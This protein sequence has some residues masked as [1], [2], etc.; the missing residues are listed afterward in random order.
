MLVLLLTAAVASLA[1]GLA[2]VGHTEQR[3][4]A[5]H[6]RGAQ[7][8]YA[9]DAAVR[10]AMDAIS[11]DSGSLL[12]PSQGTI[13]ALPGGA[14]IMA[15]AAGETVDLDARTADLNADAVRQWP[16]G[17]D[18]PRWR[19]VAWGGLPEMGTSRRVAIWIADDVIDADGIPG[20][21]RNGMLMI[22]VEAF[23]PRGAAHAV[24][25]HVRREAGAVRTVSWREE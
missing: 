17:L 12:W 9:A 13:P 19:L 16:V 1:G 20:E 18:T 21:D 11:R 10:L 5:A 7:T 15:I 24:A 23:G 2:V 8:A 14:R 6:L 4:A 25:A 3:I 22:H